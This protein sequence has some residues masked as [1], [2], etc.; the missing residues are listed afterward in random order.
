MIPTRC[1]RITILQILGL[2]F[3]VLIPG[4]P[5]AG[6]EDGN[7]DVLEF[8]RFYSPR[9]SVREKIEAI[10]VL[11]GADVR[12]AVEALSVAFDDEEYQVR[13]AAIETIGTYRN[14]DCANW[15]LETYVANKREKKI[16]R[17]ICAAESLGYMEAVAAVEPL[18]ELYSRNRREWDLRKAIASALGHIKSEKGVP[19]LIELLSDREPTLRIVALDSLAMIKK[20]DLCR[21][22]ILRVMAGDSNW[23]VRAAAI[24]AVRKMRF[25]E[26]IQP[27]IDRMR[28]ETGRLRGDAY[29]AL[30]EITFC[31]YQDDPDM[32]QRFWDSCNEDYEVPDYEKVMAAREKRK[33]VGTRYANPEAAFLGIP[34]KSKKI[35]FVIDISGSMETQV[36]EI[37]RFRA[38][39]KDYRS[40]QRLEIVKSEL[41]STVKNLDANVE[42]NI[43]AFAT[44]L[45]WWKKKLVKSNIL[46]RNSAAKFI[47]K[48]KPIGGAMAGFRARVGL[49][50]ASLEEGKTNTYSALM[51][52]LGIPEEEQGKKTDKG[53]DKKLKA[54]VDTIYFLSD[55]APTVGKVI[56]K[57]EIRL[58][59]KRVNAVR[60]ITIHVIAIGDFQKDFMKALA[61]E[62]NGVY[63]DLG[64]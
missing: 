10:Y 32:W 40:F 48:L 15:L 39:G 31:T 20:P 9:R 50:A 11:K 7:E 60:K 26:G 35:I 43:L 21:D 18:L 44:K 59:V 6:Q 46:N 47:S 23:Q 2:A 27:L 62:N 42:F 33:R 51:A 3:F 45:K 36:T 17:L 52:A 37:E 22:E 12:E 53:H 55:G 38:E 25:K 28:E 16:N 61:K 1:K 41:I 4:L 49:R 56:D 34:T 54:G 29:L 63:V 5:A 64:K 58:E 19:L 13:Q 14:P 57:D 8:K 30:Q 24:D